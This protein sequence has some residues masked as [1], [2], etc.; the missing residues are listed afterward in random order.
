MGIK[1]FLDV[2]S[3][4]VARFIGQNIGLINQATAGHIAIELGIGKG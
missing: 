4:V 3:F 2:H 1:D